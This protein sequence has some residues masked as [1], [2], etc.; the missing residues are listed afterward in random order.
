MYKLQQGGAAAHISVK[1]KTAWWNALVDKDF[2]FALYL[3]PALMSEWIGVS[4]S[5]R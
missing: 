2:K 1:T 3:K 5:V 4:V